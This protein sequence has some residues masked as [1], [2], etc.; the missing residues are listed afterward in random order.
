M[1]PE[2][3]LAETVHDRVTVMSVGDVVWWTLSLRRMCRSGLHAKAGGVILTM[4]LDNLG[5]PD[6]G[7][8]LA[9]N[10]FPES[11]C[12]SG[13]PEQPIGNR[14]FPWIATC[15]APACGMDAIQVRRFLLHPAL[16]FQLN[17]VPPEQSR[18][19][20]A[21]F[22]RLTQQRVQ[23]EVGRPNDLSGAQNARP[24]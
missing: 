15:A 10:V 14:E 12:R 17:H 19:R 16:L 2:E 5:G 7:P 13:Q 20:L 22:G 24:E 9:G 21:D 23:V 3:T 18:D 1:F 4:S 11:N 6:V 8:L